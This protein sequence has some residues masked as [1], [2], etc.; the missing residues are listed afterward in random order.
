VA[1]RYFRNGPSRTLAVAV[2]DSATSIT[3]DNATGFPSTYPYTLI[4]DHAASTEEVVLVTASPGGSVLTVQRGYNGTT[5]YAH[6]TGAVV[7]HGPAAIDFDEANAHANA[8]TDV[9]G[10]TGALVNTGSVQTVIGRKTFANGAATTTGEVMTRGATETVSG[11]KTFQGNNGF[12]GE[13]TFTGRVR[14]DSA[15]PNTIHP[16]GVMDIEK[17]SADSVLSPGAD[18]DVAVLGV[19]HSFVAGRRY[20]VKAIIQTLSSTAGGVGVLTIRNVTDSVNLNLSVSHNVLPTT[21]TATL[22]CEDIYDPPSTAAR[23]VQAWI[24]STSGAIK[25][26]NNAGVSNSQIYIEDLGLAN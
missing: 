14:I 6:S 25:M 4:L 15:H 21:A 8:T 19:G 9:H 13:N 5:S 16:L 24:H 7:V 2:T 17:A 22:E 23:I 20:R 26:D 1:R 11:N 12:S 10:A 18:A 3:V